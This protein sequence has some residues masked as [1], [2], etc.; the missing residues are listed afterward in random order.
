MFNLLKKVI[1]LIAL[2]V[3]VIC[4]FGLIAPTV[5]MTLEEVIK[6]KAVFA[7]LGFIFASLAYYLLR[8]KK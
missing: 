1:G 6:G 2:L 5:K 4:A 8:V 7:V 3:A